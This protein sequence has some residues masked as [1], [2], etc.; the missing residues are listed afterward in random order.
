MGFRIIQQRKSIKDQRLKPSKRRQK[1]QVKERPK[2]A[3]PAGT[4]RKEES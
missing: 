4:K 1:G 3:N 2:N